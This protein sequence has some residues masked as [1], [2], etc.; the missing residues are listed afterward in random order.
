[1]SLASD[2]LPQDSQSWVK[3]QE[4]SFGD[5]GPFFLDIRSGQLWGKSELSNSNRDTR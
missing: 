4:G 5:I 2:R 1:M 3:L